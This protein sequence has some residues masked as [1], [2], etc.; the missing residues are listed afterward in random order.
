MDFDILT[1]ARCQVPVNILQKRVFGMYLDCINSKNQSIHKPNFYSRHKLWIF[2]TIFAKNALKMKI[3][4]FD[5]VKLLTSGFYEGTDFYRVVPTPY[6]RNLRKISILPLFRTILSFHPYQYLISKISHLTFVTFVS[7]VLCDSEMTQHLLLHFKLILALQAVLGVV[8]C[9]LSPRIDNFTLFH[10]N[11]PLISEI[12]VKPK[13][14]P[15]L[16]LTLFLPYL[17]NHWADLLEILRQYT[18][19]YGRS[20]GACYNSVNLTNPRHPRYLE[21]RP[22]EPLAMGSCWA[23]TA[24]HRPH[25]PWEITICKSGLLY[26]TPTRPRP[27]S[28]G[29]IA[30]RGSHKKKQLGT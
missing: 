25:T 8:F 20:T 21:I 12:R 30:K 7:S 19:W 26:A 14:K 16:G 17:P 13:P 24:Q 27:H 22:E 1:T 4:H 3:W 28:N 15:N 29:P 2:V 23:G 9:P 11:Y 5:P 10:S 6:K 18:C